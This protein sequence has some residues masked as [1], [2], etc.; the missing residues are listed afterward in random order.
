MSGEIE[1][2]TSIVE[3]EVAYAVQHVTQ[4]IERGVAR[5]IFKRELFRRIFF[6][7]TVFELFGYRRHEVYL[8]PEERAKAVLFGTI[9]KLVEHKPSL[10]CMINFRA[11]S[12]W[13]QEEREGIQK[14]VDDYLRNRAVKLYTDALLGIGVSKIT[15]PLLA[16]HIVSARPIVRSVIAK[17]V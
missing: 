3:R 5:R 11:G 6:K 13:S 8:T 1:S 17:L 4:Q 15:A 14:A 12:R 10:R 9:L 7:P 16:S 2:V